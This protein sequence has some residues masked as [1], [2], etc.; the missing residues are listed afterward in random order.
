MKTGR[1]LSELLPVYTTYQK[2]VHYKNLFPAYIYSPPFTEPEGSL[3]YSQG[4]STGSGHFCPIW[5][6]CTSKFNLHAIMLRRSIYMSYK[7]LLTFKV[8]N[9]IPISCCLGYS[10]QV[11]GPCVTFNNMLHSY[12]GGVVSP[13]PHPQIGGPL[14]DSLFHTAAAT[15]KPM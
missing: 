6:A 1:N 4:L 9:L 15:T 11:R 2:T 3:P 14:I 13:L 5:P 10:N 7:K 12:G 8:L